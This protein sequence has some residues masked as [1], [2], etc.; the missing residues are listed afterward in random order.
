[1]LKLVS[2]T[3]N[4]HTPLHLVK[5]RPAAFQPIAK[6]PPLHA[7]LKQPHSLVG[8][9]FAHPGHWIWEV[10]AIGWHDQVM[11]FL[12]IFLAIF[13]VH[14]A[15]NAAIAHL[16][17]S[18]YQRGSQ[19]SPPTLRL[20]ETYHSGTG[21]SDATLAQ[22]NHLAVNVKRPHQPRSTHHSNPG[23]TKEA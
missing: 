15:R 7:P 1:M 2:P 11:I 13:S 12:V 17:M 18:S 20:Y 8:P 22:R 19:D 23:K 4:V 10:P 3:P 5:G 14:A 16:I 21:F 9:L 6:N